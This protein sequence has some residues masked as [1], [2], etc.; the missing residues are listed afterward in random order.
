MIVGNVVA[1]SDDHGIVLR[2]RCDPVVM[3]NVIYDCSSA[4]I[5]AQNSCNALLVNNTIADC[6]RGVRFFDHT[7][8]WGLPYCLTP[9]SGRATMVNCVIWNCPTSLELADSPYE[10]D[11]GAHVTL[12]YCDVQGGAARVVR[13]SAS[14]VT[15]GEGNI[16]ADPLFVDAAGGD[17]HVAETSPLVDAG[18]AAGAP[19]HD[20]DGNARPCGKEVDIGATEYGG[21]G[22]V[23]EARFLR[24]DVNADGILDIS[25]PI[26]LL[27]GLFL[28]ATLPCEKSADADDTGELN[29]AD[30]L[31]VLNYLFLAGAP[32]PDPGLACGTDPTGDDLTCASYDA[33]P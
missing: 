12:S 20:I 26:L 24:G 18:T 21:C 9:G 29:L 17:F 14:T 16:D 27:F 30:A 25:D 15:W 13:G 28:D 32:P 19:D 31:D 1:G 10:P 33:C 22:S 5:S 11:P 8:R 3:N 2:D 4:G 7:D 23:P 6:G